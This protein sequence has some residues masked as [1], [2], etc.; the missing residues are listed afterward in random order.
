MWLRILS[1][2]IATVTIGSI[3]SFWYE[4]NQLKKQGWTKDQEPWEDD[5]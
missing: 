4:A 2:V 1:A 3:L 5:Q